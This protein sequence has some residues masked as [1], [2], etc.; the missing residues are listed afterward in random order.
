MLV[1]GSPGGDAYI[2]ELIIGWS[3]DKQMLTSYSHFQSNS[4]KQ[5][6]VEI[7]VWTFNTLTLRQ[8]GRHLPDDIFKCI[9]M[10]ENVYI[11]IEISLKF[12]PYGRI[13]NIPALVQIMAWCRIGDE[14]L[15]EPMMS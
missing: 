13:D 7:V 2:T 8:N 14:P 9:F 10:I 3:N 11:L 5:P 1:K 4:K 12:V 6:S 15:S